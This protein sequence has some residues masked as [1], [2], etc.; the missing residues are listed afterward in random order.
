MPLRT[1]QAAGALLIAAYVLYVAWRA[2]VLPITHDEA[3]TCTH[4]L[5]LPLHE[6]IGYIYGYVSANN[7]VLNTLAIRLS[8][9]AFGMEPWAVRLPNVL[10]AAVYALAGRALFAQ[11]LSTERARL[12]ALV[13]WLANPYLAEFFAL[14]RG[15]GMSTAFEAL[16][17]AAGYRYVATRRLPLLAAA[18]LA[19]VAAVWASF[20]VLPFFFALFA[21][22]AVVSL[23]EPRES[24]TTALVLLG[25]AAALAAALAYVPLSRIAR[26]SDLTYFG[27]NTFWQDTVRGMADCLVLGRAYFAAATADVIGGLFALVFAGALVYTGRQLVR[28]RREWPAPDWLIALFPLTVLVTLA[29]TGLTETSNPTTRTTSFFY[30]L[31]VA[32]AVGLLARLGQL[33]PRLATAA[34]VVLTLA[35]GVNFL[36]NANFRRAYEW[37]FDADTYAVLDAIEQRYRAAGRQQPYV[38]RAQCWFHPSIDYHTQMQASRYGR[39]VGKVEEVPCEVPEQ[40]DTAVDFYYVRCQDRGRF[41][42]AYDVVLETPDHERCLLAKK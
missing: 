19:A 28:W 2:C 30:P 32:S 39:Y 40:I 10:C 35:C 21:A 4:F 22:L 27:N 6:V 8:T 34:A 36:L 1:S 13:V 5:K 7:H 38:L 11:L 23:G 9:A 3:A 12:A 25:Q 26:A 14:G 15:Y 16:A 24:R 37:K 42:D 31:L 18:G 29:I 33:R 20:T 17:M 41:G